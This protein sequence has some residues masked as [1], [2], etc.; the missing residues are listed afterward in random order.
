MMLENL[1]FSPSNLAVS[2]L[3]CASFFLDAVLQWSGLKQIRLTN[4]DS[5][6]LTLS[7]ALR[8]LSIRMHPRHLCLPL[9]DL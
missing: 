8:L 5:L 1:C 6:E 9:S 7:Q 2:R 3:L 4:N